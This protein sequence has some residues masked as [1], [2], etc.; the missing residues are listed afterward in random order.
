MLPD[1]LV[2]NML[3]LAK[4]IHDDY[5]RHLMEEG[6]EIK[7][8]TWDSLP[9]DLKFS[10]IRQAQNMPLKLDD[11]GCYIGDG[12]GAEVV[13]SFTEDEITIMSMKE[14]ELWVDER[15]M[16][17]WVYGPKKDVARKISD[18]IVPWDFLSEEMKEYDKN[19]SRNII[20]LV[21][22]IGLKVCR[23]ASAD[24]I[25]E[26][27]NYYRGDKAPL[28]IAIT[29]HV[30][31]PV[32]DYLDIEEQIGFMF[33]SYKERYSNTPIILM[34]ALSEG[35]DRIA[36]KVAFAHGIHVAPV[37]PMP[38]REY[39][40]TFSGFGYSGQQESV[41]DFRRILANG[42]SYSP[43]VLCSSNVNIHRS[44]RVLA[45][46]LVTNSHVLIAAWDGRTYGIKGGTYD[47]VRMALEGIDPDLA[48]SVNPMTSVSASP[49]MSPVRY[50][51]TS[52]DS[53]VFWIEVERTL[54][55]EG[56]RDRLCM[57]PDQRPGRYCGYIS[58]KEPLSKSDD[59]LICR[60][61]SSVKRVISK[62]KNI[63]PLH[64]TGFASPNDV[65]IE[66]VDIT[67]GV[68]SS[69]PG[70]YD[71]TF[72]RMDEMNSDIESLK[73]E[74]AFYKIDGCGLLTGTG[75][76]TAAVK[77][78]SVM[79][80]MAM[81]F[82][83]MSDLAHFY[84]RR[85]KR[86][87]GVLTL[88]SA[89]SSFFFY[90]MILFS[91]T[92]IFAMLYMVVFILVLYLTQRH[93]DSREHKKFIE[94]ST[95]A[96]SLRTEFYWGML[97]IND[98]VSRNCRGYQKSGMAWA[99]AILKG[100]DSYFSNNYSLSNR[101]SMKNR[102]ECAEESWILE[103]KYAYDID[104]KE[105]GIR[106]GILDRLSTRGRNVIAILSVAT[107]AVGLFFMEHFDDSLFHLMDLDIGSMS[108]YEG[109]GITGY[110]LI[111]LMMI[112]VTV[113]VNIVMSLMNTVYKDADAQ[114]ISRR[115]TFDQALKS[116]SAR[117]NT[118][119]HRVVEQKMAMFHELG[120][121]LIDDSNDWVFQYMNRDFSPPRK[122]INLGRK[123]ESREAVVSDIEDF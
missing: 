43:C 89:I 86:M 18:C 76:S 105:A 13:E 27:T 40:A 95:L 88:I 42:L 55:A 50:L 118:S 22:K 38:S 66:G 37:L 31:V 72:M 62:T 75:A 48:D 61:K 67:D 39:E 26:T 63:H 83:R 70:R 101:V 87:I 91:G 82:S 113:L 80:D 112:A 32:A 74:D 71:A 57:N 36:A 52:E 19:A 59:G 54:D 100:Y 81:R 46:Y 4:L 102:I 10:N 7:Y 68:S 104:S 21:E 120:V 28:I 69:L 108:V 29:G 94:Y 17:G 92:M 14:H 49:T 8:P 114:V 41:D 64:D 97:G 96:E 79:S 58:K 115:M 103:R 16:N 116:L 25:I 109:T 23:R 85:S 119:E 5:N 20:P 2:A 34:S 35:P 33:D 53:P 123:G 106:Y 90:C 6:I 117:I 122:T 121:Q 11:I 93:L 12:Q 73:S 45:A 107:V 3:N 110:D 24:Q 44:Y 30:D 60:V 99:S 111:K 47:C 84:D 77:E 1:A 56:L 9:D 98:E 15:E 78:A 51:D 65:S